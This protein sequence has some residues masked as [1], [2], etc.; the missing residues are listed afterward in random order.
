M[1]FQKKL[2]NNLNNKLKQQ[3]KKKRDSSNSTKAG[4]VFTHPS[5]AE[6][7]KTKKKMELEK[8]LLRSELLKENC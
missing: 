1:S 5:Q 4:N 6:K 3:D 7:Y 2:R 8:N